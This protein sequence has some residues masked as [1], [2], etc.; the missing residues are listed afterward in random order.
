RQQRQARVGCCANRVVGEECERSAWGGNPVPERQRL[1]AQPVRFGAGVGVKGRVRGVVVSGPEAEGDELLRVR[2]LSYGVGRDGRRRPPREPGDREVEAVPEEM[3][4]AGLAAEP[5]AE[6]LKHTVSPVEDA[7]VA[8]DRV[9]I[10]GCVL[11]VLR[12]RRRHRNP[13]GMLL[14]LDV[15]SELA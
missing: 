2:L 1:V 11:A 10:P 3:D 13:E 6:L 12:E 14:D 5:A 7:A 8:L 4:G 15:D 9:A